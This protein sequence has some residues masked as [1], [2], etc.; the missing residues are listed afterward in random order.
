MAFG[1]FEYIGIRIDAERFLA[2]IARFTGA[3]NPGGKLPISVPRH[4]G[5]LPLHYAHRPSGGHSNW[6]VEYVDG[7]NLP[8][9]PFG[10]G[11]SYTSFELS[12]LRLDR[13]EM[14]AD[15][16]AA[17]SVD[18]ANVGERAGDEV[19]QLYVRDVEASLTRPLN[20]LH[21]SQAA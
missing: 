14:A 6:N 15:G 17:V 4:V 9:W 1:L 18:V 11:L 19:V 3:S 2:D 21:V 12:D 7:S 5:Q 10:Y 8:L 13:S 20:S 16:E